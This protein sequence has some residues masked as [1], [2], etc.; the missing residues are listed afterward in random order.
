MREFK[1]IEKENQKIREKCIIK[2]IQQADKKKLSKIPPPMVP[3]PYHLVPKQLILDLGLN[4][5]LTVNQVGKKLKDKDKQALLENGKNIVEVYDRK[6][7]PETGKF[8]D[9]L[10][11]ENGSFTSSYLNKK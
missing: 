7:D 8:I 11:R 10:P 2:L 5:P 1:K 6:L 3:L 9:E 4:P